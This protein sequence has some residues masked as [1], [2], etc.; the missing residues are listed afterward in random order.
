M[1]EDEIVIKPKRVFKVLYTGDCLD[2]SGQVVRKNLGLDL[3]DSV[4]YIET[5]FLEDQKPDPKDRTYWDRLYSLEIMPHHVAEANGLVVV[6]PWVKAAAFRRG[7][8]NLVVIGRAGAGYDKIDLEACTTNNAVVFN[9]PG[10]LSHSTASAALLFILA[11]AKRLPEQERLARSGCWDR[12]AQV[13][14]DDLTGQTLGIVGFGHSGAELARLAAP[15]NMRVLVYSHHADPALV[16]N[17]RVILV[18]A[19]DELLRESDFISLHCRLEERTRGLIGERELR[20]MKPTAY[21]INVARGEIVQQDVLVRCL[22]ERW[23]AGAALD[24]FEEEP[25]PADDPLLELDNVVLTPHFLPATR[26]AGRATAISIAEGIMRVAKGQI[27][28]HVLN[29]AVLDRPGFR[30]K[31]AA[32]AR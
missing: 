25:L 12:Q 13:I 8:E 24:V 18:P 5:G 16:Q 7:A 32:F 29:P 31:L 1:P 4:P 9:S 11:L 17:L 20:L 21:F 19:L 22:R 2:P 3:L 6:R 26:Q 14:G 28:D 27:P 10:T 23:I 30:A 15:F